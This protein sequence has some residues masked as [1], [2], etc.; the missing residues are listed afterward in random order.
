MPGTG[1]SSV[2]RRYIACLNARDWPDLAKFVH[3]HVRYNGQQIGAAAY[4]EMLQKDVEEIPD[5]FF[6]IRLLVSEPPQIAARLHFNCSPNGEFL[7]VHV[8]GKRIS[9]TENVFY[10][11]ADGK[12]VE[13]WSV[14]DKLAIESQLQ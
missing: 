12:I 10:R 13:V 8:N 4:R 11:F 6:D 5:L 1:L 9:F 3:D 7:G 2:Y 14:I